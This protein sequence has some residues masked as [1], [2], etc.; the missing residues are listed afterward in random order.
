MLV[1][2]LDLSPR[3]LRIGVSRGGRW[4]AVS[5]ASHRAGNLSLC[6]V[7]DGSVVWR[8][9]LD[10]ASARVFALD[11]GGCVAITQSAR[12]GAAPTGLHFFDPRGQLRASA[13]LDEK[14]TEAQLVDGALI[15][16][17][18][19]GHLYT[20]DLRGAPAWQYRVPPDAGRD[21]NNRYYRP[22]PYVIRAPFAG[23]HIVFSSWD[24]LFMLDRSGAP[25]W[26]WRTKTAPQ[27]I[28]FAVPQQPVASAAHYR[29]LGVDRTAS[30]DD[31]RH[32]F[33]KKAFETHPDRNAD[34]PRAAEKFK[35]A[36]R[37]YEAIKA[38]E[39]TG[40]YGSSRTIEI[41]L[42]TLNAISGLTVG[43][44]GRAIV[45]ARDGLTF[46]DAAGRVTQ[47]LTS[48]NGIGPV[49][50]STDLR[51]F[52][53]AQWHG[54]SFY[55]EDRLVKRYPTHHLYNVVVRGD[56]LR[57]IAWRS[58]H[59]LAF[60][61]A[62]QLLAE[63]EFARWIGGAAFLADDQLLISAG[64]LIWF[65]FVSRAAQERRWSPSATSVAI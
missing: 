29:V 41:R 47:H 37:A 4:V 51:R 55:R 14:P 22:S 32:A 38:R 27:T 11:D 58:R 52:V 8:A 48:H 9:K 5:A 10:M 12:P 23:D 30:A 59:V 49:H 56:G 2:Q 17:C 43:D 20:Y 3:P 18:R 65:E 53:H 34:D 33:R 64:T 50:A 40:A 35:E 36:M 6:D 54:L 15:V 62:G 19:D 31:V 63:L 16:G 60:D 13:R 7:M 39:G 25:R 45:S 42:A 26:T 24:R 28:R 46:I 1:R 57:V 61:G 21:L 44:D